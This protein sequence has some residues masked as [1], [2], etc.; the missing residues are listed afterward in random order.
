[1]A[2]EAKS[3]TS[4]S[5]MLLTR[6]ASSGVDH[7]IRN[8]ATVSSSLL[9]AFGTVIDE[10]YPR[11][12]RFIIA[13]YD[14]RYRWWQ[15]FLIIL[16]VYSAWV[17]PFEVAFKKLG[18]GSLLVPD[19]VV[20]AFFAVDIVVSFFVAYLD[21]STYLLIDDPKKI[22]FRYV[23]RSGFTMDVASTLPFQ[24]IYRVVTGK[25]NGSSLF[26]FINL[27]RLWR[28]RRVGDLFARL[29]KDIR[30]SYFWTRYI[31]LIFVT[32]FAVHSAG[33]MYYWMAVHYRIKKMTWIGSIMEDF[34]SRGIWLGYVYSLYWSIVTLSTVGYGDLHAM[35]T[36]ERVFNIFFMLFNIGLTSYLIGNMTNLIVHGA[37]RT[38]IMRDTIHELSRYAS[39]NRL[40]DSMKEQMMSHLQLKFK[41]VELQQEEVLADLPKAIRSS[42]AQHLFQR[43]VET[44]YLFRGISEDLIAQLVPELKAE[45]FPPKVDII[46]QNEIPTDFYIVVSGALDM[47]THNNGT[48]QFLQRLGPAEMAGEIGVIFNIPQPFTVRSRR[49]SQVV[50]IGHHLFQQI[51]Q[52]LIADGNIIISNFK[53]H[54]KG[55]NKE[56]LQEIPYIEELMNDTDQEYFESSNETQ[57]HDTSTFKGG[58]DANT[59][60][61]Q[62]TSMSSDSSTIS[63]RV[64]IHEHHPDDGDSKGHMTGKVVLLPDS[65][66]GLLKLADKKFGKTASKVLTSDGSEVEEINSIRE[67][68]HLFLC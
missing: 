12:R 31:K 52:P 18:T 28:L 14:R 62:T 39:K 9:P 22:A 58:G 54:L 21:K 7:Q 23:A 37:I 44:S 63:K 41:T 45:Y 33:C 68:D 64:I 46:L 59:N 17:S 38:F 34:E 5:P 6:R 67:N 60:E 55:L 10:G 20:D 50:R 24:I 66:G 65:I 2:A 3:N 16:V 35:N 11:L 13:P 8:L 19:L 27:L 42:I 51:V 49:L 43:T 30:F 53:Q 29:E 47:L 48:E 57:H 61:S 26:A 25:R 1:M 56:T 32:L 40:P 4:R 15:M 36:G